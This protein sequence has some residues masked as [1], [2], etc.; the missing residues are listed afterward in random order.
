MPRSPGRKRRISGTSTSDFGVGYRE[1]HDASA[2]Y[3][4]FVAPELSSETAI[5]PPLTV[6]EILVGDEYME[7]TTD[8][9]EIPPESATR[10]G[11][12]APFPVDLPQRLIHL[13]TYRGDLVLDPFMGSGTTAVAAL[14]TQR[15]FFGYDSE[16]A[17]VERARERIVQEQA[18]L[19]E[20]DEDP[21]Q[22]QL[23]L[24]AMPAPAD[25]S[26]PGPG[27]HRSNLAV[28]RLWRIHQQPARPETHRHPLE[29]PGQ[30]GGASPDPPRH[31]TDPAHHRCPSQ[32]IRRG[33][34]PP[35]GDGRRQAH[36][37]R[38]PDALP[39]RR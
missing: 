33:L 16:E 37:R 10:V 3:S 38:D 20:R 18:L 6:D 12:P 28:R 9:W 1:N 32:G 15:H 25:P 17:Y 23:E 34:R 2:F 39:T 7:A 22:F 35:G 30:G 11:H 29:G 36:R 19:A 13:Y 21:E 31:P 5:A 8:V 24:P 14:R 26:L 4:P 27:P